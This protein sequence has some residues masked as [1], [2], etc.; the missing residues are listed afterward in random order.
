MSLF[1]N[2][3]Y[4]YGSNQT[5]MCVSDAIVL[6]QFNYQLYAGV[7]HIVISIMLY[8][9][10]SILSCDKTTSIIKFIWMIHIV[11]VFNSIMIFGCVMVN[12]IASPHLADY[13]CYGDI[14]SFA[15]IFLIFMYFC[16]DCK[17]VRKTIVIEKRIR[18]YHQS[19]VKSNTDG[20]T[21]L[22]S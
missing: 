19:L 17:A 20:D 9:C 14:F 10:L 21:D 3:K 22:E 8:I 12:L 11:S 13:W 4:R 16:S 6:P 15:T 5:E 7:S 18:E 1:P 2:L